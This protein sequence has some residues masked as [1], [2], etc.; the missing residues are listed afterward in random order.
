[1]KFT[2]PA[3][4]NPI[5]QLKVVGHAY[6]RL[7]GPLKVAGQARYAYE[8]HEVA[9]N[10]L[11]GA[12]V[13]AGI[14]HGRILDIDTR[15]A[16][17][18]PGVEAVITGRTAG[19]L[20]VGEFYVAKALAVDAVEHYHQAVAV[21]VAG[22][23]EQARE[24]AAR[25]RVRYMRQPGAF[26]L[27]RAKFDDKAPTGSPDS[28][29]GDFERAFAASPVQVDATYDTPDQSHSMMEPHA[30]VA[31][32]RGGRLIVWTSIQIVSWGLRDLAKIFGLPQDRIR[33][34]S[35]F[36]GGGFGGKATVLS[37]AV[38]AA[39]AARHCGRP[40]KLALERHTMVN[41]TTHRPATHQR[42]RLGADREGRLQAIGHQSWSGNLPGGPAERCTIPTASLYAGA[43]RL[44]QTRLGRLD[45]PEG[46]AM[47]APGEAPGLMALEV[48]MDELAEK[49]HLDPVE[50]RI[51]NDTAVDP[52]S[53]KRFGTRHFVDCLR[54][55]AERFGW[56][57]RRTAPRQWIEGDDYVG[58]GVAS[59]IRGNNVTNSAARVRLRRNGTL[60]VETD[61]TDIGTG[62]YTII[63]QTAAEML[64][65]PLERVEVRLGDSTFPRASGSLGQRGANS[66]TSGTYAACARLRDTLCATA[67]LD[68]ARATFADGFVSEGDRRVALSALAR[69]GEVV[70]EDGIEFDQARGGLAHQT[71]GAHFCEVRVNRATGEAR[72][73]R[74][75]AVCAAGRI[76]NPKTAR[77]QV[78]GAMTMG[79]G[80]ALM[81]SL[82]VDPRLGLFVNHDLASYEVPVHADI[83]E[84]EV[85]FIDH[86]DPHSS[87]MKAQGVSELGISGVAAAVANAVYNACGARVRSYPVTIEKI[88]PH[89]PEPT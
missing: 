29:I 25:V 38:L 23:L 5:D 69:R 22:S 36:I 7:D 4:D 6:D 74:M 59:A 46:N 70:V 75:L 21:V 10:Q 45:M 61:M 88:L 17:A 87:P 3:A 12:I 11:Y 18:A 83:I 86:L 63:G 81:E 35:P 13:A 2:Q 76:L 9:S 55:G 26:E 89:L 67:G 73:T 78:I 34:V 52:T 20:D 8:Q 1:M 54:T 51:R 28:H 77:S 47:R 37:D 14:G 64:G 30:T 72:V 33:I 19:K 79:L 68:P 71:F 82:A 32:W 53:G 66:S 43:N 41:N 40:V 60:L 57:R 44:T 58:F 80:A 84:Q 65:L 16:M 49:L 62:S 39:L 15:Y 48:A 24:G 42:V 85:I 50:L 27:K 56:H 31:A